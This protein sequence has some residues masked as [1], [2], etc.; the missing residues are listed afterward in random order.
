[1]KHLRPTA[2]EGG[3]IFW[4]GRDAKSGAPSC[5]KWGRAN[6]WTMMTHVETLSA[7]AASSAPFAKEELEK[8]KAVFVIHATA[9]SSVQNKSDGR[10]HQLLDDTSPSSYLETSCTA[11]FTVAMVRGV[12][13]GWLDATAFNPII[14]LAWRGLSKV[15]HS[16]GNVAG[17]CDWFGI[18]PT[19][20]DYYGCRTPYGESQPGLGSVL[21]ALCSWLGVSRLLKGHT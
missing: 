18:H 13:N 7:L 4:H 11:M 10:W 19:A 9:L 12:T 14:D 20:N 17:R 2:A 15:I 1:M 21:E 8:A 16:D 3:G 6:G 5:C